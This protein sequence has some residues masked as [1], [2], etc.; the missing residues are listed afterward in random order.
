MMKILGPGLLALVSSF[1]ASPAAAQRKRSWCGQDLF[2][3]ATY[4]GPKWSELDRAAIPDYE[5]RAAN[6]NI[7][8]SLRRQL[9]R[10]HVSARRCLRVERIDLG[11]PDDEP[12]DHGFAIA[13]I[14]Q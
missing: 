1:Y 5:N 10:E 2:A 8:Q 7:T 3:A 11:H 14:C 4:P 9:R 6:F 13:G 12:K